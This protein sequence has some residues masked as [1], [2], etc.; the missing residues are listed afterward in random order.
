[1]P[2][3]W[4]FRVDK[5]FVGVLRIFKKSSI[6]SFPVLIPWSNQVLNFFTLF[7]GVQLKLAT[8]EKRDG[9]LVSYD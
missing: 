8:R 1:M 3:T 2:A 6:F 9:D 7:G 5:N 4:K